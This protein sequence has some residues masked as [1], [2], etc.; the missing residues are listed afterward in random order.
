M[1]RERKPFYK[2]SRKVEKR[3]EVVTIDREREME[4]AAAGWGRSRLLQGSPGNA[5]SRWSL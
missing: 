5:Y 1:S 4:D 3:R 2:S